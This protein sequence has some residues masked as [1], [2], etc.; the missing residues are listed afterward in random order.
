LQ[1]FTKLV[2]HLDNGNP[3]LI[4]KGEQDSSTYLQALHNQI[5]ALGLQY[6]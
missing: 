5:S 2:V 1:G 4:S 3:G 6:F